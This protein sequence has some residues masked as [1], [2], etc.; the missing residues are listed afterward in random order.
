MNKIRRGNEELRNQ[1]RLGRPRRYETD[2][3]LRSILRDDPN[4]LLRTIADTSSISMKTVRT[5]I[6]RVGCTLKSLQWIPHA[7]TNDLKQVRFNLC[8]QLLPKLR[9][10]AHDNWRHLVTEN[11]SW[12]DYEYVR[13]R[14]WT[15]RNENTS[16]VENRALAFTKIMLTVL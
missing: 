1:G 9:A 16:E 5:H 7:L 3:T 10:H 2:A 13:D 15:A 8:L 6:S 4:A 11:E 14:I 12:F